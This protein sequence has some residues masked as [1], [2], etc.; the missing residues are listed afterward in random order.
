MNKIYYLQNLPEHEEYIRL[1]PK[2]SNVVLFCHYCHNEFI[3]SRRELL[4]NFLGHYRT[5]GQ[6]K[7]CSQKC[8]HNAHINKIK[9]NCSNCQKDLELVYSKIND[10]RKKTKNNFCSSS[11]SATYN[12]KNKTHGTRRSKM[13]NLFEKVLNDFFPDI[14][15]LM[16]DKQT[17][18][19]ELDFYFP[20][21]KFA[22]ELNGI[23]HYEPIY[24]E[25]KLEKI[26]NNDK[27]KII[28]CYEK[29]IEL[30][31]VDIA[32]VSYLNKPQQEKYTNIFK[33]IMNKVAK[34]MEAHEELESS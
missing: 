28:R 20:N 12:N 7:Y 29:G 27:Q 23:F 1:L 17:I 33:E 30:C 15:F 32:S 16:N 21:L 2:K 13:E 25:N 4:K 34:R 6:K 31:V 11:C 3:K 26:Q 24:G 10:K 9:I 5:P 22:V 18:G 14:L 8:S 19:S